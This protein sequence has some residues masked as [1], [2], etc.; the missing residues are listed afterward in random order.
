MNRE[1]VRIIDVESSGFHISSYPIEVAW[2]SENGASDSFLIAPHQKW[3]HW[4][5][6][7][8]KEIHHISRSRLFEEGLS[9]SEACH[10]LNDA[11]KGQVIYSDNARHDSLWIEDL[12][13]FAEEHI[14]P[15]F[16]IK[17]VNSLYHHMGSVE[18]VR[19]FNNKLK[20]TKAKHRALADCERYIDAL[21]HFW[22]NGLRCN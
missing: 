22:P 11:L 7:A 2:K 12:F 1:A 16:T 9:I 10:R 13:L 19:M 20:Q 18:Q 5:E 15:Q 6:K 17:Q 21:K 3:T 4:C 8:E 14:R